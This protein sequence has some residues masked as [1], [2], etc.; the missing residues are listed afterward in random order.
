[1]AAG[2]KLERAHHEVGT[3]GQAEINYEF[4][5][6]THAADEILMFKY[7]VKN[8]AW[9][10]GKSGDVYAEAAVRRQRLGH[11][12][13]P[14]VVEGR[15]AAVL[16]RDR[17]RRTV[18]HR[19]VLRRR[20]AQARTVRARLHEPDGQQSYHRLVPG[21]EAPVNLV[22]SAGNRSA[23]IRVP[24]TGTSPKAKRIEYRVPDPSCQPLPGLL[25]DADGRARRDQATRS[26]RRRPIDKDLYELP[27]DEAA[28]IP[29]VPG[30]LGAVLDSLEADHDYLLEGG[31]FTEDLIGA[32]INYKRV[33]EVDPVRLRPHPYEFDLYYNI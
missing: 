10:N 28:A 25:G 29:Q 2:L 26:S 20:P 27:P 32:W 33:N 18:G 17:L 30:S 1:M 19:P 8:V 11:A 24:I 4:N 22:Y 21:Y 9:R 15:R 31:V 16:R 13:P 7:I 3:G 23:C 12:L 6:L 14:V 5:T